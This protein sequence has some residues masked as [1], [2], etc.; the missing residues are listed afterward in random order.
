MT[1]M[2]TKGTTLAFLFAHKRHGCLETL[3]FNQ[4]CFFMGLLTGVLREYDVCISLIHAED[5]NFQRAVLASRLF[6][7]GWSQDVTSVY[8]KHWIV[9]TL[10]AN[11]LCSPGPIDSWETATATAFLLGKV[12]QP[13]ETEM[14]RNELKAALTELK[15]ALTVPDLVGYSIHVQSSR[16]THQL[17]SWSTPTWHP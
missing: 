1:A 14:Y 11:K 10:T 13:Q 8:P 5:N 9:N 12:L 17:G 7:S 4:C 6:T 3:G 16:K 2:T 15:A